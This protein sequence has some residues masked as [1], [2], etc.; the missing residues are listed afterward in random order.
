MNTQS[1]SLWKLL[2]G[3][4]APLIVA[5]ACAL[6]YANALETHPDHPE[7]LLNSGS[8]LLARSTPRE[9]NSNLPAPCA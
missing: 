4:A 6:A 9:P 3:P 1:Q 5:A 2:T 7:L 8:L